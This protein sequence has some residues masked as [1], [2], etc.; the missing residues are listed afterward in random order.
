MLAP[1]LH[2]GDYG[3]PPRI[4]MTSVSMRGRVRCLSWPTASS[5]PSAPKA[6]CTRLISRP[7]NRSGMRTRCAVRRAEGL[8]RRRRLAPDRGRARASPTS[9]ERRPA[10][11]PLTQR[12][13]RCCGRR[14]PIRRA[15]HPASRATIAGTLRVFFTRKGCSVW[16]PRPVVP[17]QRHG[18]RAGCFGQCGD[19]G[20]RSATR[21][22]SRLS[23]VRELG[24]FVRRLEAGRTSGCQMRSLSNHY[25]TSVYRDG[26]S[27]RISRPAGVRPELRAVEMESG[28]VQWRPGTF[29]RRN[30]DARRESICWSA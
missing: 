14:V 22:S 16:I 29:R 6:N 12:P 28:K 10:S 18:A 5:L 9:A 25:A 15:T 20:R 8:L 13:G 24:C 3:I 23:T 19:A 7:A 1:A 21:F 30:R 17:F 27:L 4:E 11:S 2:N 26:I